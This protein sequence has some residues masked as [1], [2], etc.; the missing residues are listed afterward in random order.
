M[1]RSCVHQT[2]PRNLSDH[3]TP[4]HL[5]RRNRRSGTETHHRG[6]GLDLGWLELSKKINKQITKTSLTFSDKFEQRVEFP[7]YNYTKHYSVQVT[8]GSLVH[9]NDPCSQTLHHTDNLNRHTGPHWH[10]QTQRRNR[11]TLKTQRKQK[12]KK[13][14]VNFYGTTTNI[15]S[16]CQLQSVACSF[17]L[18][19]N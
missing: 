11:K 4:T 18:P 16:I 8:Y 1:G 10:R 12:T 3:H 2:H 19:S 9:Q 15:C 13:R 14:R 17:L 5:V 7:I 6:R